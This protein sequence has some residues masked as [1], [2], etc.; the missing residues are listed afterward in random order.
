MRRVTR[1]AHVTHHQGGSHYDGWNERIEL[2]RV[3]DRRPERLGVTKVD[4]T[5]V[6]ER[7]DRLTHTLGPKTHQ[8]GLRGCPCTRKHGV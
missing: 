2:E 3:R 4:P 7:S 1:R 6:R 5:V 8:L